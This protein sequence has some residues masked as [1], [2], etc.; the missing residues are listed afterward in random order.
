MR[1]LIA[2]IAAIAFAA[3]G[4]RNERCQAIGDSPDIS[5]PPSDR[6]WFRANCKCVGNGDWHMNPVTLRV[7]ETGNCKAK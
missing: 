2:L 4:S 3:C 1:Y 6:Q 5:V 7:E